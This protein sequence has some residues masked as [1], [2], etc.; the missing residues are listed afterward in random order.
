MGLSDPNQGQTL[1]F[2][3]TLN[4]KLASILAIMYTETDIEKL[5]HICIGVNEAHQQSWKCFLKTQFPTF[6]YGKFYILDCYHFYR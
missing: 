5:L 2:Q 1:A 3:L 6:Y 4:L